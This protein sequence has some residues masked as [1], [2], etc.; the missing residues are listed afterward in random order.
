[1]AYDVAKT[2]NWTAQ[3]PQSAAENLEPRCGTEDCGSLAVVYLSLNA[4]VLQGL[5][6]CVGLRKSSNSAFEPVKFF[7]FHFEVTVSIV[8][9]SKQLPTPKA[10]K[11]A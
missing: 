9:F 8:V 2:Q 3:T 10:P 4:C 5:E 7:C 1:M 11:R 6:G